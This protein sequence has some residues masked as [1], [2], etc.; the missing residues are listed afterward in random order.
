M[1]VSLPYTND[2]MLLTRQFHYN[3]KMFSGRAE[4]TSKLKRTPVQ[5][6]REVGDWG[7]KA[8]PK[9]RSRC[10]LSGIIQL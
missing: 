10:N 6:D 3:V 9:S 8:L 2:H 1:V 5:L 4:K 7:R